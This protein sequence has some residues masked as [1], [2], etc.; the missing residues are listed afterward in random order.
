MGQMAY[1]LG[2]EE[3]L[4]IKL[5]NCCPKSVIFHSM[6]T[7]FQL[8]KNFDMISLRKKKCDSY[9]NCTLDSSGE[10]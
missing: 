7:V 2:F 5:W 10:L 1:F 9:L 6:F 4:N 8:P 3:H